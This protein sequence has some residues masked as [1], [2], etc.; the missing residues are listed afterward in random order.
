VAAIVAVH[1]IGQQVKGPDSLAAVWVPALRDGMT[2]A[3]VPPVAADDVC[4]AFYG[5]LYRPAGKAAGT[6]WPPLSAADVDSDWERLLLELWW[7]EAADADPAVPA[8]RPGR[9]AALRRRDGG[10][11]LFFP[12]SGNPGMEHGGHGAEFLPARC[13]RARAG[14][15]GRHACPGL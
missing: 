12:L 9:S 13:A 1:G 11:C 14:T 15:P 3:G 5:G 6:G 8:E 7:R 10:A 4:V 2:A